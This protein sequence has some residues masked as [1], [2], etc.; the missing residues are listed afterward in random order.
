[1]SDNPL[2]NIP[3]RITASAE[4]LETAVAELLRRIP[5]TW[6]AYK[7][8]D[9]SET[10]SQAV[11][12]LTAA[13]M[14]ERRERLRVQMA[15]HPLAV[16]ATMTFTGAYGGVEALERLTAALWNDWKTAYEQWGQGDARETSPFHCER[17]EPAE[18]RLTAEGVLARQDVGG[19]PL[20]QQGV[21]DFVLRRGIFDGRPRPIGGQVNR[22]GLVAGRGQLTRWRKVE[23][24]PVTAATV[25]IGNWAEGGEAFAKAFEH[26]AAMIQAQAAPAA[27]PAAPAAQ[28]PVAQAA[29][30]ADKGKGR[31]DN[32]RAWTQPDLDKAIRQYK[33]DRAARYRELV[34]AIKGDKSIGLPPSP[35]AKKAAQEVYGRNAIARA[36]GVKSA[37]MVSKS[38]AW[39]AIAKELEIDLRRG[40]ACGTWR[41]VKPGKIGLEMALEQKSE[42]PADTADNAPADAGLE[43]AERQVT[44]SMINRLARSGKGAKQ[45]A[46]RERAA[47]DLIR[48]LQ[49]DEISDDDARQIVELTLNP[50][51]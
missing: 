43:S 50:G 5:E 21:F 45:K 39:I 4:M 16:E 40:R 8:D 1:M 46:E 38:P 7:P 14:V 41:T 15:N 10:E 13:G 22:P 35:L 44:I 47:E 27:P 34:Y 36:L 51:E 31:A 6:Q 32:L 26:L 23:G 28:A 25:N 37:A 2:S 30:A 12:L 49:R 9:L 29:P 33:A 3:G 20:A 24:G 17:G 19:E 11:F 18:W 42:R 48:K